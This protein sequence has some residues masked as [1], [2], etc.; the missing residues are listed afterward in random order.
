MS[1]LEPLEA[2]AAPYLI[3]IKVALYGLAVAT[4]L[5]LGAYGMH[6]WDESTIA[7]LK[8]ADAAFATAA[9]K[10]TAAVQKKTDDLHLTAAVAEA[11]AQTQIIY[12]TQTIHDEVVSHVP[13]TAACIPVGFVR[14]LNNAAGS[15]PGAADIAPGQPDDA[16]APVSWRSLA[17]DII[18]DYGTGNQNAEQLN[19]LEASVKAD[20]AVTP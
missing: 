8:A 10:V 14:L 2:A 17:T 5:G 16:C 6:R 3:W 11:Q 13:I 20:A 18:D 1:L 15:G 7:D 4:L 19:A 9:I 12:R